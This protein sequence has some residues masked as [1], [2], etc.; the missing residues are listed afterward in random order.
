MDLNRL[1][2]HAV[3]QAWYRDKWWALVNNDPW[4]STG[5]RGFLDNLNNCQLFNNELAPCRLHNQ[6]TTVSTACLH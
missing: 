4:A 6:H 3:I 2:T 1:R 5:G